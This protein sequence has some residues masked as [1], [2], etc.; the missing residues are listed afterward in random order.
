MMENNYRY[1]KR[2]ARL[3]A[4]TSEMPLH[5]RVVG[6]G[7]R[8]RHASSAR[9]ARVRGAAQRLRLLEVPVRPGGA[10]RA[11][12]SAPRRSWACATSTSTGRA[13]STRAAWPRWRTTSS[14]SSA[15]TGK[16]Q[17]V[18]RQRRL[19]RRRA[20][21]RFRLTSTTWSRSTCGSS[22]IRDVS[23]IF[24]CG[25]GAR[26]DLQR[27]RRRGD[28]RRAA[29]RGERRCRSRSWREQG[30]D[31]IRAVPAG[32][33]RQVPELHPGRPRARCARA[34]YAARS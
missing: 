5:L 28:Q 9:S 26:A 3:R 10:A 32:P 11:A 6:R 4:R 34:G 15:P 12:A 13:S 31:R 17:A 20:A 19:R 25:T 30:A 16:V 23:G 2:A 1:S 18:R 7:L 14:T 27:R 8:R 33:G 24:N 21:A 22:S 29:A